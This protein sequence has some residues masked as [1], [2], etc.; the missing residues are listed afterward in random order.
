MAVAV[1]VAVLVAVLSLA[2][3]PLPQVPLKLMNFYDRKGI[4]AF[5]EGDV[6][7]EI[8]SNV[9]IARFYGDL[10]LALAKD[11]ATV[12]LQVIDLGS[13]HCQLGWHLASYLRAKLDDGEAVEGSGSDSGDG[14]VGTRVGSAAGRLNVSVVMTDYNR[15]L[16]TSRSQL[17]CFKGRY[18]Q[19]KVTILFQVELL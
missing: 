1:A 3:N 5:S 4:E 9:R 13:G 19:D 12:D 18:S 8:S 17:K 14:A 16:L 6:P 11:L 7:M 15:D 10:I 2:H